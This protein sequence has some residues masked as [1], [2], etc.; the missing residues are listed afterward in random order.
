[1]SKLVTVHGAGETK[2]KARANGAEKGTELPRR[3]NPAKEMTA[4]EA[5][6]RAWK[7]AYENRR[8]RLT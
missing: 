1:M 7:L 6:L 4:K 2:A 3:R 8:R 5:T